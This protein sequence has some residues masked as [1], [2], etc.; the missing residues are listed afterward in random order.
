MMELMSEL[1]D[2][3]AESVFFGEF[4]A[5]TIFPSAGHVNPAS[6]AASRF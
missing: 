4:G 3:W 5:S 2:E 1:I 6:I